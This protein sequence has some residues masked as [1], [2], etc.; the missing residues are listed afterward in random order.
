MNMRIFVYTLL[1]FWAEAGAGADV[2]ADS[3]CDS[4]FGQV[5]SDDQQLYKSI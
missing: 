1:T 4:T 5:D 3:D 2:V